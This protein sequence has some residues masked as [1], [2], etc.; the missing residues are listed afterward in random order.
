MDFRALQEKLRNE[1]LRRIQ[2]GAQTGASLARAAGM[3]PSYVSHYLHGRR[4]LSL[5]ALDRLLHAA[6]WQIQDLLDAEFTH[7]PESALAPE[8]FTGIYVISHE[9][10]MLDPRPSIPAVRD[11]VLVP[12]AALAHCRPRPAPARDLWRRFVAVEVSASQ[13]HDMHPL[14]P[15]GAVA[16]IDRHYNSLAA[17]AA[18][19]PTWHAVRDGQLLR[20]AALDFDSNRLILRPANP[21]AP[22][23]L[24]HPAPHEQPSDF[25]VG[26]L[27]WLAAAL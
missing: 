3:D 1:L 18:S 23:R 16:V 26:R 2:S 7:L 8:D 21:A 6:G 10:A 22:V 25:I 15:R 12:R 24:I 17:Y 13:A 9:A 11:V 19:L 4:G 5:D 27:C 14:L 20:I